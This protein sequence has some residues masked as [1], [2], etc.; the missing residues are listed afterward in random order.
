M[1]W[2]GRGICGGGFDVLRCGTSLSTHPGACLQYTH[3]KG[4][5]SALERILWYSVSPLRCIGRMKGD[6]FRTKRYIDMC[7]QP[8]LSHNQI[9]VLT[10]YPMPR[11]EVVYV[12]RAEGNICTPSPTAHLWL[13]KKDIHLPAQH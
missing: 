8:V 1:G 2:G 7:A 3:T 12:A 13:S 11:T 9:E 6:G 4:R 10:S 5:Q